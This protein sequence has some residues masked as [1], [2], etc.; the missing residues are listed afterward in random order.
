MVDFLSISQ[1]IVEKK[2]LKQYNVLCIKTYPEGNIM[3][4]KKKKDKKL[5]IGIIAGVLLTIGLIAA[6]L[7][8]RFKNEENL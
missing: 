8:A 7:V 3:I 1:N 2:A 5:I 4:F 6:I